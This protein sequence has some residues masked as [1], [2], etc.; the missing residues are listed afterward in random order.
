MLSN[1]V[2]RL[3]GSFFQPWQMLME[4]YAKLKNYAY[5]YI[6]LKIITEIICERQK[7]KINKLKRKTSN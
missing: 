3:S 4:S 6:V 1:I 7:E 2:D 5:F